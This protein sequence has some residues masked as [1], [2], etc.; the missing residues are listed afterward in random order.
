MISLQESGILPEHDHDAAFILTVLRGFHA[1]FH[2][3]RMT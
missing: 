3:A 1:L 2:T